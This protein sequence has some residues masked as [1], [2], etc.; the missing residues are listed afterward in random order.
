[1]TLADYDELS[2]HNLVRHG[3]LADGLGTGKADGL[4]NAVKAMFYADKAVEIETF[5]RSALDI[6]V[7]EDKELLGRH[8]WLIDATASP[9]SSTPSRGQRS[10]RRS[11]SADARSPTKGGWGHGNRGTPKEP[12]P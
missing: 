1:M 8:S 10:P 6:L 11:P 9:W 12:A 7:E 3:L 5:R 2:P 4:K